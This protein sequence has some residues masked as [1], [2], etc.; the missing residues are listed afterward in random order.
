MLT[1][2]IVESE[3]PPQ[4]AAGTDSTDG[5]AACL[6]QYGVSPGMIQA[7]LQALPQLKRLMLWKPTEAD[8]W[9]I[10]EPSLPMEPPAQ[11]EGQ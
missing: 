9:Q 4:A 8:A 10:A 11:G 5:L 7:A 3:P 6:A 2:H 1:I